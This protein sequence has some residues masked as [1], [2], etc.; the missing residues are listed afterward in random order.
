[1]KRII[2]ST[3]LATISFSALTCID[4]KTLCWNLFN[5]FE[6]ATYR[7]EGL[8]KII[9]YNPDEDTITLPTLNDKNFFESINDLSICRRKEVRTLLY[10]YLT[11][12]RDHVKRA[13][14][15]SYL[16]IDIIKN[17]FDKYPSI[18]KDIMLLPLLESGFN[19]YAI[20]RSRAVGLWQ[21][22]RPTSRRL[23]LK[24]DKWIDE[25]R[26]IVKSTNAAIRHLRNLYWI[27][28]SWELSLAAYNGGGGRVRRAINKT[29]INDFW[30]LK[31]TNTLKTETKEYVS[32]YAA[33]MLI[34][35]NQKLFGIHEEMKDIEKFD[36]ESIV[37]KYPV[38]MRHVSKIT[39][40]PLATIRKLNP[41][42]IRNAI[43]PYYREYS[44]R[45]PTKTL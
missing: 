27:F 20:S 31:K 3:T 28:D 37:L 21:F 24:N 11:K 32:R 45:V 18:P 39:G 22:I 5:L 15:R 12:K 30:K 36:T 9:K 13:I 34:Y 44:F 42:L 14:R 19:P 35:K 23:G 6:D 40:V 43:P 1:M 10:I 16:Y 25:R 29:G 33:L 7:E 8:K 41:E 4:R 26:D 38:N 17:E 2:I